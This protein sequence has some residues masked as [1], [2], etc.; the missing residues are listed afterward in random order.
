MRALIFDGTTLHY[1]D[2]VP[3]PIPVGGQALLRIRLA[4]ICNTDLEIIRGYA[5]FTGIPGHEFVGEVVSGPPDLIGKRV[6]GE[7]N[8][9]DGTCDFC[10]RGIRSQCPSRSTVG[11]R[12]HPG[13]F[14][15]YLALA[16]ENLHPVPD[17]VTDEEAVFVEPLAAALQVVE[18][19]HIRPTERVAV[20]GAGKLG[21]LVLQV[22]RLTGAEVTAVVR[23]RHQVDLI[24]RWG[25][26]A[27]Y[28][29]ELEAESMDVVVDCA[30]TE[31]GFASA[32][33]LTRS[34][35]RIVL[36]STFAGLASVDLAQVVVREI[37]L[38]GSRCGPFPA[39][40]RL[41]QAKLIDTQSL[42]SE[43]FPLSQAELAFKR[44]AEPGVRKVLLQP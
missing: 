16:S 29:S 25:I 28:Q 11:I 44:A 27:F 3:S 22:L 43:R 19:A 9:V 7:I 10:R 1:R 26:P 23:H 41:L 21:L 12:N 42:I 2:D 15:E 31:S 37:T 5:G 13:A 18:L 40:L 34:R 14:A 4:G 6:V 38:I 17:S 32:L 30:G 33:A 35:G 8:V 20:I 36:K 24:A 39:A